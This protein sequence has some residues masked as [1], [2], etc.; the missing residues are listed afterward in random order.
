MTSEGLRRVDRELEIDRFLKLQ[1]SMRIVLKALF[2][3][4]E[5]YLIRNNK[6]F[7]ITQDESDNTGSFDFKS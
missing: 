5:R 3:K 1:I 6:S 2:S 7:V 4:A